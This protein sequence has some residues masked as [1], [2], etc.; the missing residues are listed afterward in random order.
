MEA[1]EVKK[2]VWWVGTVDWV[3]RNFH[4]YTTSQRGTTYNAFLIKDEK[5]V[6]IDTV[7]SEYGPKMLCNIAH[8]MEP[9]KVDYIVV[10]HLE[11][12]HSGALS[13]L[14]EKTQPEKIFCS[15]MGAKNIQKIYPQSKDWP[16]V[17]V[18]TGDSISI[19]SRT[20]TFVELRMMHWPDNMGTY[21]SEDKLF[22]S[23]DAFGQNW[24]TS[25]KFADEV[26]RSEFTRLLR[27]YYNN[28]IMPYSPMVLKK[29]DEIE[30]MNIEIDMIL[31]DHGLLIRGDDVPNVLN[32]Y[33]ELALQKPKKKAVIVYDTM[34]HSTEKMANAVASG[35]AE[36]GISVKLFYLKANNHSDVMEEV[37]DAG[38]VIVGSPTHNNG[39][40]PRVADCLTYMKGL[41]P[42]KKIGAAIGS[43]GWSGESVNILTEHLKNMGMDTPVDPI[44]VQYVPDH[45]ILKKC[46]EM[47]RTLADAIIA[48]VE[49]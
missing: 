41:R 19:G 22:I 31:P 39:I 26:D 30:K 4:G 48:K 25:E 35:L 23:S 18:K 28:I 34:W 13:L 16:I 40:M 24:A 11:Q 20:L 9:E 33:R 21:V 37:W 8:V 27:R 14:V 12:D 17:P 5:N 1:F 7:K 43:F 44:K 42:Q 29:L 3:C 49:E 15:T 46:V 45:E 6:L 32:E 36:K 10:N 2:D 47:G 38:A